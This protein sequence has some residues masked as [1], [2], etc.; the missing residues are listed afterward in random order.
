MIISSPFWTTYIYIE[1]PKALL[2]L[3]RDPSLL[4]CIAERALKRNIELIKALRSIGVDGVFIG[5]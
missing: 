5:K 4:T 3:Y 1:F 2:Y